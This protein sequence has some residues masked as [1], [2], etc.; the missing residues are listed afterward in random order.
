VVA[1]PI[2]NLDDLSPRA[3]SVLRSVSA[4]AA[5]DTRITRRLLAR[6]ELSTPLVSHHAHSAPHRLER[7]LAR[8]R[9]GDLALVTDAGTPGVSDPGTELVKRAIAEGHRVAPIPGPSAIAAALSVSGLPADSYLFLGFLPRKQRARTQALASV[10]DMPHTLVL[11]EAPHRIA[12]CLTDLADVLGDRSAAIARELTK[13]HEEVWHGSLPD[14]VA[15]F[16][17]TEPRGEFT[18]VV[19][20]LAP[21]E[22]AERRRWD[23]SAVRAAVIEARDAGDSPRPAAKLI[24]ARSGWASSDVYR[25][26]HAQDSEEAP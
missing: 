5:E 10:A 17:M 14:A 7:L 26:W 9:D 6:N 15:H 13:K 4:I 22:A 8:L 23:E 11:Y 3:L 18:I 19:A 24:A 1:T 20:G 16:T 25:I 12:A 2:G 21:A